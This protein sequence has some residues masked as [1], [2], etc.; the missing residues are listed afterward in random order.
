MGG[1]PKASSLNT[2]KKVALA[3][4]LYEDKN[5]SIA[6]ICSTLRVSRSTLYRYLGVGVR[7]RDK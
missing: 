6:D 3:Q 5:N 4:A 1:R 2:D 7:G